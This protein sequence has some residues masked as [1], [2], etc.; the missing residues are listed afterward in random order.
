M[1]ISIEVS[2]WGFGSI[3]ET[4]LASNLEKDCALIPKAVEA[5]CLFKSD[6]AAYKEKYA[7]VENKKLAAV[8]QK[9]EEQPAQQPAQQNSSGL[10]GYIS[11]WWS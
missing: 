5:W 6:P 8:E 4:L 7:A 2:A 3:F 9:K 10:A 1:D 11:S